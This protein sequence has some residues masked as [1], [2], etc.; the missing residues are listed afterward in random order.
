[1]DYLSR[2]RMPFDREKEW[3]YEENQLIENML[4]GKSERELLKIKYPG[5]SDDLLNKIL[6]DDNP[7]RKAE[8]LATMDEYL[9]LRELKK[10][11][12]EAY[13]IITESFKRK[14]Q[15]SGGI[16]GQL[17][18][19]R[20][21]YRGGKIVDLVVKHGPAFKK[22][23]DGLFIKASNAIRQGKGMGL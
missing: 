12:S 5:I 7:Q 10:S 8:V 16:A 23:A 6:I 17:H 20:P 15:A 18:L 19:N 1:M 13:N 4:K 2:L 21:G 22:F 14:K 3:D 9:K 11:E